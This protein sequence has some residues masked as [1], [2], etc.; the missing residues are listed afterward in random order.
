MNL[1]FTLVAIYAVVLIGGL[2]LIQA[3]VHMFTKGR[4]KDDFLS[5]KQLSSL[6][7]QMEVTGPNRK[8]RM[9]KE[10]NVLAICVFSALYFNML[11]LSGVFIGG[12]VIAY[13][14]LKA[15]ARQVK[16]AGL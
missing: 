5:R 14:V 13:V 16:L 7:T 2:S 4:Y 9:Y 8:F 6:F 3:G 1:E 11:V 15:Q 12:F 10:L